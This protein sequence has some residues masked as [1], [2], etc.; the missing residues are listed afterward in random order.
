MT[1]PAFD[2]SG[3]FPKPTVFVF[4]DPLSEEITEFQ[5]DV[6]KSMNT[7][8]SAAITQFPVEGRDNINDHFQPVPI[9][10]ALEGFIYISPSQKT[11]TVASNLIANAAGKQ[12][13]GLSSTFASAAASA[14]VSGAVQLFGGNV[15][16]E[17]PGYNKLLGKRG[18]VDPN[19]PKKAM[20]GLLRVFERGIP[21]TIRSYFDVKVYTDMVMTSLSFPQDASVGESLNFSMTAKK[22]KT[23]ES[24]TKTTAEIKAKD[25]ANSSAAP[26]KDNGKVSTKDQGPVDFKSGMFRT[27]EAGRSFFKERFQL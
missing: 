1:I 10:V 11:L 18:E 21:F 8:V 2:L 3:L 23:V 19:F 14:A 27:Q 16:L 24:F 20:L 22:I 13:Q 6:T 4:V 7:S 5:I 15:G 17:S 26:K 9:T 12:F 25:P